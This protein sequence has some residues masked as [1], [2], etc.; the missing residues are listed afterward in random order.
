MKS[1]YSIPDFNS[2]PIEV[3]EQMHKDALVFGEAYCQVTI[4]EN[5]ELQYKAIAF[6]ELNKKSDEEE[7]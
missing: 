6:T 5:G 1:K 2:F 3:R 7:T 4:D